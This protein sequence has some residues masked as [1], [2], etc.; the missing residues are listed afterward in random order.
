M[1]VLP[2]SVPPEHPAFE[3]HFPGAPILPG[4]V[5]LDE[6]IRAIES[7]GD[8]ARLWRIVSVKFLR[9]VGPG[10]PLVLEHE[11]LASG[12]VRFTVSSGGRPVAAGML[13]P[14]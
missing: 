1:R 4:V 3:G 7:A 13:A 10:T 9:G 5:L 2:L 8:G 12:A 11:P 14:A 6:A